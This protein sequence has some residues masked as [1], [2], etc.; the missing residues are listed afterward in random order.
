MTTN[1]VH[2]QLL[3]PQEWQDRW[4]SLIDRSKPQFKPKALKVHNDIQEV[5]TNLTF[6]VERAKRGEYKSKRILCNARYEGH[7]PQTVGD[8]MY[9]LLCGATP[10]ILLGKKSLICL[11]EEIHAVLFPNEWHECGAKAISLGIVTGYLHGWAKMQ[12]SRAIAT[13]V[14]GFMNDI[15]Y[16]E[17]DSERMTRPVSLYMDHPETNAEWYQMCETMADITDHQARQNDSEFVNLRE[18]LSL[19]A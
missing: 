14:C 11:A 15:S 5:L 1:V 12:P 19:K 10:Q 2:N 18:M 6:A 9:L 3:V 16:V 7:R 8:D 4:L 13:W 17:R